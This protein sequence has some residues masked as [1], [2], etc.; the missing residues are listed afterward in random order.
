MKDHH[1]VAAFKAA[2]TMLISGQW[3]E[4]CQTLMTLGKPNTA[5]VLVLVLTAEILKEIPAASTFTVALA[6]LCGACEV[7]PT[8]DDVVQSLKLTNFNGTDNLQSL[9]EWRQGM[10][11]FAT[12]WS[13]GK[14][15]SL[16]KELETV[17]DKTSK[18]ETVTDLDL[19]QYTVTP[20]DVS[21]EYASVIAATKLVVN[22]DK[23]EFFKQQEKFKGG[24]LAVPTDNSLTRTA[25]DNL[26]YPVEKDFVQIYNSILLQKRNIQ[27]FFA[28]AALGTDGAQ[29]RSDIENIGVLCEFHLQSIQNSRKKTYQQGALLAKEKFAAPVDPLFGKAGAKIVKEAQKTASTFSNKSQ[30][31]SSNFNTSNPNFVRRGGRSQGGRRGRGRSGGR[32]RTQSPSRRGDSPKRSNSFSSGAPSAPPRG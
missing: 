23:R 7:L 16:F 26:L 28:D 12:I 11:R 9:Q 17:Q 3:I 5:S 24:A 25:G 13:I 30:S 2:A 18:S 14:L 4:A 27:A 20:T 15:Q 6:L 21:A 29:M 31:N 1:A 32:G 8:G 22:A 10:S 19:A